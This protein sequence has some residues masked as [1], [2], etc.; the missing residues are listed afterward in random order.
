M[1]DGY[2]AGPTTAPMGWVGY[3]ALIGVW[4]F[5]GIVMLPPTESATATAVTAYTFVGAYVW[6]GLTLPLLRLTQ[7]LDLV[8]EQGLWR[9]LRVA[10]LFAAGLALAAAVSLAIAFSLAL[11]LSEHLTGRLAG[12]EGV[13]VMVRYRLG[14]DML[15]CNLV[16]TA[17]VAR[18]YFLRYRSRVAETKLLQHQLAEARLEVL[19]AQ[20][21]PHFLFNTLNAVAALVQH[22]PRGVRRM[23]ALLSELLRETLDRTAEPEVPLRR[24]MEM[25]RRYLEI[26]EIRFRGALETRVSVDP[27]TLDA[28]VPNLVLQP[29]VENA[30]KHGVG[31]AGGAGLLEIS[32]QRDGGD[33]VLR[34]H[35]TGAP[36]EAGS[37]AMKAEGAPLQSASREGGFGL[38]QTRERLQQL[39][40]ERGTLQL[41]TPLGG[42]TVAEVRLPYHRAVAASPADVA[43]SAEAGLA[44]RA[45]AS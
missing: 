39:Y 28:L 11:L 21:N 8:S 18:D 34:V 16:L 36:A 6:A 10:G 42:G 43:E 20:L 1:R 2:A 45:V 35:D 37:K 17:G 24:E 44:P 3:V 5:F 15:A 23:I 31:R 13:W 12:P 4:T 9:P 22:D 29:L 40:G 32:A 27:V 19:R 33:L 7:R 30:L 25:L 38:R 14:H 41:R 26:M